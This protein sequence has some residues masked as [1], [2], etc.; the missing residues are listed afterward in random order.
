[1]ISF[2]LYNQDN[3]NLYYINNSFAINNNNYNEKYFKFNIKQK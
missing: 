3:Y 1:M 2:I